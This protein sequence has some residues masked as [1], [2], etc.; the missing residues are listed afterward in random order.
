MILRVCHSEAVGRRISRSGAAWMRFFASAALWLLRNKISSSDRLGDEGEAQSSC[1]TLEVTKGSLA[2]VLVI[3]LLTLGLIGSAMFEDMIEHTRQ[4]VRGGRNR[5]RRPFAGSQ[6][7]II[8]AQG[9]LR[10]PQRLRR[11]AQRL[12]RTAVAFEGLAAQHLAPRDV[13]MGSQAQPRGKV[14]LRGPLAHIGADLRQEHLRTA[15]LQAVG[16]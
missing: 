15:R 7:A 6:P 9:R 11:Q 2:E 4:L 10:A 3:G 13:I 5:R 16:G 12:R 1:A 14:L 8:T